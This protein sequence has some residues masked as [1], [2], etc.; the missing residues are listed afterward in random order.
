MKKFLYVPLALAAF[1]VPA[2]AEQAT[3]ESPQ[4]QSEVVQAPET[5]F[6]EEVLRDYQEGNYNSFLNRVHS[7]YEEASKKWEYNTLLEERKK[8]SALVQDYGLEKSSKFKDKIQ[9]LHDAQDRELVEIC[10]HHP[11][12]KFSR[13]VKDMVFFTPSQKEQASLDYVAALSYKYKGDGETP[14]ENKLI[15]I[16]TEF[17]LKTLAVGVALSQNKIDHETFHKQ[18]VVLQLEKLRQMKEACQAEDASVEIKGHIETAYEIAPKVQASAIARKHLTALGK[19]KLEPQNACE[20]EMRE[21][22]VKYMEKEQKL[23]DEYFPADQN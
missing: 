8:L 21:I 12:A 14:L 23:I 15:S 4:A 18:Q 22:M 9:A 5:K 1:I 19:G 17:W 13:E 6:V 2:V 16:D 20:K 7:Q 11:H 3:L 10:L